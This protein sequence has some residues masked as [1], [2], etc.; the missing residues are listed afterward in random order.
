[1]SISRNFLINYDARE[2]E[3]I[4]KYRKDVKDNIPNPKI[5]PDVSRFSKLNKP[6]IKA[7]QSCYRLN[8]IK[9]W[10]QLPFA[11]TLLL[12]LPAVDEKDCLK[13]CGFEKNDISSMI[14]MSKDTG[15]IQFLLTDFSYVFCQNKPSLAQIFSNCGNKVSKNFKFTRISFYGVQSTFLFMNVNYVWI[16]YLY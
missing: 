9:I 10:P 5:Y 8:N 16:T 14:R 4:D 12:K 11:G 13:A 3:Q 15:K 1:M 6:I 7:D 2:R